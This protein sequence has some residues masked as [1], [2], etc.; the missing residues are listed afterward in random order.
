[1]LMRNWQ[2]RRIRSLRHRQQRHHLRGR[3]ARS[4]W[5][6]RWRVSAISRSRA[7]ETD[8]LM[9]NSNTGAFEVYDISNNTITSSGQ[10]GQV[11][12]EWQVAGFGD[13]SSSHA[14]ETDM[15]MRNSNTGAFEVFDISQQRHNVVRRMGQVG[16]S[17][18]SRASA[19]S[20]P[21]Q[22]NRH[23]DAQRTIAAR[24]YSSTSA[25]TPSRGDAGWASRP[26]V[27]DQRRI[28]QSSERAAERAAQRSGRRSGPPPRPS[29]ATAQL[30][31]AM[32]SFCQGLG[33]SDFASS[34]ALMPTPQ[35]SS[36][37][38]PALGRT[39]IIL[40]R[41]RWRKHVSETLCDLRLCYS[42]IILEGATLASILGA[43]CHGSG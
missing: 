31:Q 26:G 9:R 17:G 3:W 6:G 40:R 28:G 30:T 21:C 19:I 33:A 38:E 10:M 20:R 2:Y 8:M 16:W 5:S 41:F 34:L 4:A 22:R 35:A 23:A 18:R 37:P 39:K 32:A 42:A 25:T 24:S 1:M 13:F 29:G 7:S 15:L 11:G 12:L 27:V 36:R 43:H 14:S